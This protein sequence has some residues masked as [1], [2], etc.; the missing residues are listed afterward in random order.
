MDK[1]VLMQSD[2]HESPEVGDVGDYSWEFHSRFE[3]FYGVDVV[4]K[5][6]FTG[7]FARVEPRFGEFLK[8]VVYGRETCGAAYEFFCVYL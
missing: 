5:C 4:R 8:D 6:E 7:L 2:V 1:S 3:I